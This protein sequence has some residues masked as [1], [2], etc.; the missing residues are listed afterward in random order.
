LSSK[1]G[2]GMNVAVFPR[3]IAT[4]LTMY[5][6]SITRSACWSSEPKPMS[7]SAWPAVPTSWCCTSTWTPASMSLSIISVR[8]SWKWSIGGTGK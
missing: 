3:R 4:F 5:F 1:T 7:I 2:F 8:M 6:M